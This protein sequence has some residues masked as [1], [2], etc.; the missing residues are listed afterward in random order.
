MTKIIFNVKEN[1]EIFFDCE[2]HSGD[3]DVCTIVSTLCNVLVRAT[4]KAD[5]VVDEYES[6]H[7]RI[8]IP[9]TKSCLREQ[10]LTILDIFEELQ[11]EN[12]KYIKIY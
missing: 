12:P 7:V 6:G 4:E 5:L 2:N 1:G 11:T 3:H 10:F 8:Y 9:Q